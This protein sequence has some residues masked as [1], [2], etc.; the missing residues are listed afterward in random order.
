MKKLV[1]LLSVL[2]FFT[3]HLQAQS[4][5]LKVKKGSAKLN[6]V[7]ISSKDA[8][9]TLSSNAKL[10]VSS[11]SIV[12]LKQNKKFLQLLENKTYSYA[13]IVAL[14]KKQKE[15]ASASYASSLFSDNMQ[16]SQKVVKS[17]AATRGSGTNVNWE[18]VEF[19]IGQ[20]VILLSE[21]AEIKLLSENVIMGDS[22]MVTELKK[23]IT[24]TL[25]ISSDKGFNISL[26]SPGYY[27]WKV[28]LTFS[29]NKNVE[30]YVFT[31]I[32]IVPEE[33][34]RINKL[35]DWKQFLN[36]IEKLDSSIQ[37]ELKANY[38]QENE[39]YIK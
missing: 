17:G 15:S 36:E 7:T 16:K 9:K 21:Q 39:L 23:K 6:G 8:V 31:G 3:I 12:V 33:N 10:I 4:I 27:E 38:L 5:Y 30:A 29:E 26:S 24:K 2:L 32:I 25:K 13:Q 28:D 18:D 14:L 35:K 20:E 11:Q 34:E 37:E 19:S 1:L 22:C